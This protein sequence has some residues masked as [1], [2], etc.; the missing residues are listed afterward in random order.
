MKIFE[1]HFWY[2]KR[3][4]N[5]ILLLFILL[6]TAELIFTFSDFKKEELPYD[7]EFD[8]LQHKIDSLKKEKTPKEKYKPKP[9]NPNYLSD[10]KAYQIGMSTVEIDKLFAFRRAGKFVNTTAEFQEVT[11]IHDS[12]L[13][14]IAPFFKFPQWPVKTTK[15]ET[16]KD[17]RAIYIE[18]NDLNQVTYDQLI[19][20]EGVNS[21]IAGRVLAY[22]KLLGGYSMDAQLYEVYELDKKT[23]KRILNVLKVR[24]KPNIDR[25]NINTATFKEILHTPYIDYQLTK[26]IFNYRNLNTRF[27]TLED[28]K[29][30]D[31]FPVKKFDRIALYLYAE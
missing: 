4:R 29:K 10:F 31:S 12:L 21:K 27:E 30:I 3:Q 22:R 28:L 19:Q 23:A 25:I 8:L 2:N 20:F 6:F 18:V 9:F 17:Q 15:Y 14:N 7:G 1:S 26:K 16:T 13:T 5:G 11:G 24:K